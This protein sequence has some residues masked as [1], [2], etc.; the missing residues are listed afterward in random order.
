MWRLPLCPARYVHLAQGVPTISGR[1]RD[2]D[3][4]MAYGLLYIRLWRIE[5]CALLPPCGAGGRRSPRALPKEMAIMTT[6]ITKNAVVPPRKTVRRLDEF[7]ELMQAL[8]RGD[9]R[10]GRLLC[11]QVFNFHPWEKL[12]RVS[13]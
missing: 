4:R 11:A 10:A 6:S 3:Y 1:D 2:A 12:A 5:R 8:R 13:Q 9:I 7:P